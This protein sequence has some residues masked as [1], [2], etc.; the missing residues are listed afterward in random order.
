LPDLDTAKLLPGL[1]DRHLQFGIERFVTCCVLG[2][3]HSPP[4]KGFVITRLAIDQD[5]R[6]DAVLVALDG[7]HAQ[8]I[9]DRRE[10]NIFLYVLFVGKSINH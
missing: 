10:D 4:A 1:P 2:F 9:L 8:C 7:G 6:I 5:T 3:D